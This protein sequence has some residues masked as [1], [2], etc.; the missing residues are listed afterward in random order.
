LSPRDAERAL[1]AVDLVGRAE[2]DVD[3]APWPSWSAM[4]QTTVSPARSRKSRQRVG[5]GDELVSLAVDRDDRL[6]WLETAAA[7]GESGWT[8]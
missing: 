4:R 8:S 7:A 5:S 6:A 3:V 1:S 2:R